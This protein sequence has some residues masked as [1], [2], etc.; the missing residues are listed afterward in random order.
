MLYNASRAASITAESDSVLFC[1]DRETFNHIVKTAS[2]KKRERYEKFLSRLEILEDLYMYELGQLC[3]VLVSETFMSGEAVVTQ[4][5]KGEKL[6]FI[7]RGAAQAYIKGADGKDQLVYE[8][9]KNDYFGEL[10]LLKDAPRAATIIAKGAL[11]VCSIDRNTFKRLLG[12]LDS[13]LMRNSKRYQKFL[14][15]KSE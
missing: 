1:L 3:D 14:L 4:G 9:S 7:E 2:I 6:Y 10:A 15:G 5:E 11:S 13:V 12:P 8:F